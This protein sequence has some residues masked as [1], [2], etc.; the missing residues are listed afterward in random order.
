MS[1]FY[2]KAVVINE[3]TKSAISFVKNEQILVYI[4]QNVT[5]LL[6]RCNTYNSKSTAAWKDAQN[7]LTQAQQAFSIA[8]ATADQ[9]K[10]LSLNINSLQAVQVSQLDSLIANIYQVR[11]SYT[12]LNLSSGLESLKKAIADQGSKTTA[13]KI[14]KSILQVTIDRYETLYQSLSTMSC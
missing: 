10:L 12:N 3:R 4:Q 14:K 9:I 1:L 11:V 2:Q 13:F 7:A 8:K 5:P 6:D